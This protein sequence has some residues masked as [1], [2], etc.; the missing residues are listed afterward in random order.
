MID[1]A[2]NQTAGAGASRGTPGGKSPKAEAGPV[3]PL[4]FG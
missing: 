3:G 4:A 1:K 2:K